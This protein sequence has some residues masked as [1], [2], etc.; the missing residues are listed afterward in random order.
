[1]SYVL[2]T[3]SS[4]DLS[5]SFLKELD[6]TIVPLEFSI[7]GVSHLD[8]EPGS[9]SPKDM[10]DA[11]RAGARVTTS[12]VTQDQYADIISGVFAG[13]RDVLYLCFSSGLSGSHG[14]SQIAAETLKEKYPER[15]VRIVDTLAASRGQGLLVWDAAKKKAE[16]LTLDEL[17]DWVESN[18]LHYHHLVTVNDLHQLRKGGRISATSEFV[19][20]VLDIKPMIFMNKEGKLI[21]NGKQRGRK[22]A[23]NTLVTSAKELITDPTEQ[24]M[25]IC[26]GDCLDDAEYVKAKLIEELHVKDVLIDYC[27]SVIGAHIGPGV[28]AVFFYGK[29]RV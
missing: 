22:R 28:V 24:T 18:K 23:L 9:P 6:V 17:R 2:M 25:L 11:I 3:D 4:C 1:M 27:G 26:H 21:P 14:Q 19:G 20:S 5:R 10:Y 29:P 15:T 8:G 16:G 12:Q 13:G 7:N